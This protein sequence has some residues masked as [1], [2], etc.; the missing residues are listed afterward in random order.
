MQQ[1]KE[2]ASCTISI[3]FLLVER[4]NVHFCHAHNV[5]YPTEGPGFSLSPELA[6]VQA[7]AA[8]V[9]GDGGRR[10]EDLRSIHKEAGSKSKVTTRKKLCA[11]SF[12]AAFFLFFFSALGQSFFSKASDR[13]ECQPG[14]L[15]RSVGHSSSSSSS[16]T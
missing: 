4:M 5:L 6:L 14:V 8:A 9:Q 10:K 2:N 13:E 12:F 1:I 11:P 15:L 16:S 7:S 3:V